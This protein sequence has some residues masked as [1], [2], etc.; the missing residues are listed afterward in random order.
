MFALFAAAH[1]FTT[2]LK[3]LGVRR[4]HVPK[5]P[6]EKGSCHT[7]REPSVGHAVVRFPEALERRPEG[8]KPTADLV[9]RRHSGDIGAALS[10]HRGA[11]RLQGGEH[12]SGAHPL[13]LVGRGLAHRVERLPQVIGAALDV[14]PAGVPG[15]HVDRR[16]HLDDNGIAQLRLAP[17]QPERAPGGEQPDL[18]GGGDV[19]G[20]RQLRP[21]LDRKSVV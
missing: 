10:G 8:L 18:L 17:D 12:I 9:R 19:R 4:I 21:Q 11:D 5:E 13:V 14:G 15:G 16:R 7:Y 2:P 6:S 3:L 1:V 20:L